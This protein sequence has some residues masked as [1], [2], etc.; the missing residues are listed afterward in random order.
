MFESKHQETLDLKITQRMGDDLVN[1]ALN[2]FRYETDSQR[3]DSSAEG[4]SKEEDDNKGES[5]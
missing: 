1:K 2:K 3:D 5:S 4:E